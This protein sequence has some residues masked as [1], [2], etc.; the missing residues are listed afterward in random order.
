M[1][2]VVVRTYPLPRRALSA[3]EA[4]VYA[5]TRHAKDLR[6]SAVFVIRQVLSAYANGTL[7]QDLE[8][9]QVE[10]LAHLNRC[11][12]EVNAMRRAKPP[13]LDKKTGK[14]VAPK[15]LPRFE[16][17]AQPFK[18]LD[19]TLLDNVLRTRE[20]VY[21]VNAYR[22]LPATAAQQ[23]LRDVIDS[24]KAWA[25][26]LKAY[27]KNPN[28]FTGR[29]AMPG[30]LPRHARTL[31]AFPWGSLG[32]GRF[33]DVRGKEL[34]LDYDR[35]EPLSDDAK[36]ALWDF[37]LRE[38]VRALQRQRGL[39]EH[40]QPVEIRLVPQAGRKTKAEVVF[41]VLLEQELG[42][43]ARA[44]EQGV[45]AELTGV[46]REKAL[47]AQLAALS[48]RHFKHVAGCDFGLNNL[49]TLAFGG[50]QRGT[51]VSGQRIEA[52]LV[53]LDER[54]DKAIAAATS[55]ELRAL[56]ARKDQGERLGQAEM[57]QLR[58]LQAQVHQH[59][60]VQQLRELRQHFLKDSAHRLTQ[61]VIARLVEAGVQVLV[62]GQNKGWKNGAEQAQ[63]KGRA[64]NRR[65][66]RIP[67]ALLLEH[68]RYKAQAA[69]LL[70]VTTEESYTSKT[71]FAL[72]E[73]LR[74]KEPQTTTSENSETRTDDAAAAAPLAGR[75]NKHVFKA[76]GA[77]RGWERM[78]ADINGAFNIIRKA[79]LKFKW[80]ESLTPLYE[81]LW[82]SPKKGLTPMRLRAA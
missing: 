72:N 78:H 8:P 51:V 21:A 12:D 40:A 11:V 32:S 43:V 50:G 37:A 1:S 45:S 31:V 69:G 24:F 33:K 64:F 74:T 7:K 71:S 79:V 28:S 65:N 63:D 3:V 23:V 20:D 35:Q 61:G 77:A 22:C 70:V 46:A 27:A 2:S 80:R 59:P 4:A 44:L 34:F 16:E 19:A 9:S 67:H 39:S 18:V 36:Q 10:V 26:A 56:Q 75:R 47:R 73:S 14:V 41:K 25:E 82:L 5:L 29:P 15:L 60:A 81:L 53:R 42:P 55:L 49:I 6:N 58:Q 68:L 52:R 13:K 38:A 30:Y 62:V 76:P 57:V 54:L 48:E 66:L 17:T